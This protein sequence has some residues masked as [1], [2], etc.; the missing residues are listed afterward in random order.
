MVLVNALYFKAD[1]LYRFSPD[2]TKTESFNLGEGKTQDVSMMHLDQTYMRVAVDN[3]NKLKVLE[4]PYRGD[5]L[6]MY[7]VLPHEDQ[8]KYWFYRPVFIL[9]EAWRASAGISPSEIYFRRKQ[10]LW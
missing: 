9:I 7:I 2:N 6:A 8:R 5:T 10:F 3:V 4:L 1:W